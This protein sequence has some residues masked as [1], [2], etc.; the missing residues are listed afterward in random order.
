MSLL[1]PDTKV[2]FMSGYTDYAVTAHGVLEDAAF[3]LQ[4][5]FTR[6]AL[7][8]KVRNVLDTKVSVKV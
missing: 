7:T 2:L 4:K 8:R 6:E 3:L 5:P 1:H